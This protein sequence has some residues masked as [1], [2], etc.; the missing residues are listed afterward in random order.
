M[1]PRFVPD[2]EVSMFV[3]PLFSALL[4]SA[5][6]PTLPAHDATPAIAPATVSHGASATIGFPRFPRPR[7]RIP[8][9]SKRNAADAPMALV[10]RRLRLLVTQQEVWFSEK[11]RYDRE[12]PRVARLDAVQDTLL[13][14]VQVQVIYATTKG[15]TAIASHP[16]A[17]GKSCVVFVGRRESIPII[18]RTRLDAAVAEDEG[19]PACDR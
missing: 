8:G 14:A 19:R 1:L 3:M 2:A 12:V 7:F 15:W 11:A 16:G 5:P 9:R 13:N 18:P 10:D 17:P 4:L 6:S